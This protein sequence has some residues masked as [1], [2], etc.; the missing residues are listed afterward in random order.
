MIQF[1]FCS[2][3]NEITILL[4][5]NKIK[6]NVNGNLNVA[7]LNF[8]FNKQDCENHL[9]WQLTSLLNFTTNCFIKLGKEWE[10]DKQG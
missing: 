5:L 3:K 1:N 6:L 9:R 8:L 7:I 10:R 4:E 2:F